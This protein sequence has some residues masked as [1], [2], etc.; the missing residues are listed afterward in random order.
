M[1]IILHLP[2]GRVS[3]RIIDKAEK[4]FFSSY[5]L[6]YF[7]QS[8]LASARIRLL[9]TLFSSGSVVVYCSVHHWELIQLSP[10]LLWDT[11]TFMFFENFLFPHHATRQ[12]QLFIS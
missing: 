8:L 9:Y 5:P 6:A 3:T 1:G 7:I 12:A 11:L 2:E 10:A 4:E